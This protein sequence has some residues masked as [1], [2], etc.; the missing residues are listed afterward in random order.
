MSFPDCHS[1][2][3]GCLI[4]QMFWCY[5]DLMWLFF[6][7]WTRSA[8]L[9]RITFESV[10]TRFM[11]SLFVLVLYVFSWLLWT[12]L[13]A[14]GAFVQ[15]SGKRWRNGQISGKICCQRKLCV[16]NWDLCVIFFCCT[17]GFWHPFSVSSPFS[18]LCCLFQCNKASIIC[19]IMYHLN[20]SPPYCWFT[21]HSAL[22]NFMQKSVIAFH[23]S[24]LKFSSRFILPLNNFFFIYVC[25]AHKGVTATFRELCGIFNLCGEWSSHLPASGR[26][27]DFVFG[28]LSLAMQCIVIGPVCLCVGL[29]VCG[30]VTTMTEIACIDLHQTGSVGEGSDHLRLIKFWPFC[31]PGKGVCGGCSVCISPSAFFILN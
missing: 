3:C 2:E 29:F 16:F 15:Q 5:F 21:S 17:A 28:T 30:S 24:L 27:V 1:T 10:S 9:S 6:V 26:P 7:G 4:V 22:T 19:Q 11:Y 14:H 13:S 20:S 31:A 23:Y 25:H 18:V 8:F 12:R